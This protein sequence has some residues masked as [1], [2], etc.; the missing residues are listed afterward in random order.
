MTMPATSSAGGTPTLVTL[1]AESTALC[2]VSGLA[3]MPLG[4]IRL[5][6][7]RHCSPSALRRRVL[8][9]RDD[10]IRQLAAHYTATSG[11]ALAEVISRDLRR[12]GASGYQ[13][14]PAPADDK[15][16][17]LHRALD[18]GGGK[19]PG[20]ANIRRILGGLNSS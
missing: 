1:T 4:D 9:Q 12:Y 18:L 14:N 8:D 6:L 2:M 15:R 5:F 13:V 10:V 11:R 16:G 17:L 7:A 20:P 3:S 19:T